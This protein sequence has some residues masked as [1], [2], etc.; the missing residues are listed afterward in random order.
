MCL[1][2]M[3][4]ITEYKVHLNKLA[5]DGFFKRITGN[6]KMFAVVWDD[7]SDVAQDG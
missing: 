6:T 2:V 5:K 3:D 1:Q 4:P 7:D